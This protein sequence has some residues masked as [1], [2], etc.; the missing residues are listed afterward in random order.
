MPCAETKALEEGVSPAEL[1]VKYH[2]LH[3]GI[4]DCIYSYPLNCRVL[5][6][7]SL[8]FEIAFDKFG[9]TPTPQQTEITQGMISR[10]RRLVVANRETRYFPKTLE[11]RLY[12]GT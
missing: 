9:R 4:Y 6:D 12:R 3:K 7:M 2:A 11:E 1:C 8:G 5:S 10:F